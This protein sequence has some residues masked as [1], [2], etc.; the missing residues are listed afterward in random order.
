MKDSTAN[1]TEPKVIC[2]LIR[3]GIAT[4]AVLAI[5]WMGLGRSAFEKIATSLVMPCGVLWYLMLSSIVLAVAFGQKKPTAIAV[6]IWV[7]FTTCGSGLLVQRM[8]ASIEAPFRQINP[9]DQQ[10]FDVVIVLG[11]GASQGANERFQGNSSGDRLILAA[12]LYHSG[13]AKRF[14]CTG[15][16]IQELTTTSHD[17]AELS[18]DILHRLG[19]PMNAIEQVG[20]RTTSEEM[21]TLGERFANSGQRIGVVTSAWHLRRAMSLAKRNGL[22][23]DPLPADFMSGPPNGMTVGEWILN[24]IPQADNLTALSRISKEYLGMVVGR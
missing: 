9:H 6:T 14:I 16:R 2:T 22:E 11:G 7:I 19:V 18:T 1:S 3:L 8:A 24:I 20:G 5:V 10:P 21:K 12:Q 4:L 17:P 13:I 23:A 15:K